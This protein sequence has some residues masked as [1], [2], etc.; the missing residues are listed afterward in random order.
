MKQLGQN[1]TKGTQK[2]NNKEFK[3]SARHMKFIILNKIKR[4]IQ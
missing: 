1:E 3:W 4:H 2:I